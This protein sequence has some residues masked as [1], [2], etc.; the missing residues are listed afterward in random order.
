MYLW[1]QF[2]ITFHRLFASIFSYDKFALIIMYSY[3]C[4]INQIK[5]FMIYICEIQTAI[6]ALL[7]YCVFYL[8]STRIIFN[9][10]EYL[11]TRL[12]CMEISCMWKWGALLR[13]ILTMPWCLKNVFLSDHRCICFKRRFWLISR[14]MFISFI[15]CISY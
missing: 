5:A 15:L 12:F 6:F 14:S 2:T 4:Y 10:W 7:W 13:R 3:S 8:C 11:R 1:I 9:P